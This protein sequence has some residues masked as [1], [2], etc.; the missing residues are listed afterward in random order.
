MAWAER[1]QLTLPR[2]RRWPVRLD[3]AQI[4]PNHSL[5][6]TITTT[7]SE[8]VGYQVP[9]PKLLSWLQQ[10]PWLLVLDGFDEVAAA[11]DR[12]QVLEKVTEFLAQAASHRSD[13]LTVIT[14][15]PQGYDN[16]FDFVGVQQVRL[17]GLR[18]DQAVSYAAKFA[19][20]HFGDDEDER[21]RVLSRLKVASADDNVARLLQTP[22]QATIMTLLLSEHGHAPSDRY[23]LFDAYY[24][25]IYKRE[26]AKAKSVSQN[27]SDYRNEIQQLH[28]Q[29]GLH[30]Q[31]LSEASGNFDATLSEDLLL[32]LAARNFA[33]AGYD[34]DQ[35]EQ[36]A[37]VL[38]RAATERLVL[39]VPRGQGIGFEVR[40]IQEYMAARALTAGPEP[41]IL[42]RLH[43][44][45]PSAH[46]RNPWMFAVGRLAADRSHLQAQLLDMVRSP[47]ADP[48]A[49]R[50]GIGVELA[51]GLALDGIGATRPAMRQE[52]LDI[53]L[54]A[55]SLPPLPFEISE[56]VAMLAGESP[57]MKSRVF[58]CLRRLEDGQVPA[59]LAAA[60]HRILA[61]LSEGDG[62]LGTAAR[63]TLNRLKLSDAQAS[64]MTRPWTAEAVKP[65]AFLRVPLA[66][67][68]EEDL[69]ALVEP[70][71]VDTVAPFANAVRS[72]EVLVLQSD[73][74]VVVGSAEDTA[75]RAVLPYPTGA[76]ARLALVAALESIRPQSWGAATE[77]VDSLWRSARRK[78]VAVQAYLGLNLSELDGF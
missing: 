18:R 1:E 9:A 31:G 28:E 65:P 47:G 32:T 7:V 34:D 54:E 14:T 74:A 12:S 26:A 38:A 44:I 40:S 62:P 60:A 58:S 21:D 5:L 15:R 19:R 17:E 6:Q 41:E 29:V 27:L 55:F 71:E 73:P 61:P 69:S 46:W 36:L 30:L 42:A 11:S 2:K 77:I 24:N 45:A 64:A 49:R 48:L 70:S 76:D 20:V 16:E 33:D 75:K 10:W 67:F 35:A 78:P 23:L 25:T 72:R 43:A 3:L 13:L 8:R 22:L 57:L 4:N 52:L 66:N 53:L 59:D 37:A 63:H 68:I 56:S 51:A 39:L 50:I